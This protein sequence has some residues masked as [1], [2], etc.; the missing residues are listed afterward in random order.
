MLTL[1]SHCKQKVVYNVDSV[2]RGMW[3]DALSWV[4]GAALQCV[5]I[6]I[7]EDIAVNR[8]LDC[9]PPLPTNTHHT[10]VEML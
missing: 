9:S 10:S 8:L 3:F 5:G 7:A 4:L 2:H 6:R 1:S